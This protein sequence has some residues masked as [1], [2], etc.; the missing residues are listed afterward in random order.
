MFEHWFWM[1]LVGASIAWYATITIYIAVRG[2]FD[3]HHMLS[4]LSGKE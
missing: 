1:T 3:I 4:R 2:I